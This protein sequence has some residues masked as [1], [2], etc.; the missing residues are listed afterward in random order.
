MSRGVASRDDD[1]AGS[2]MIFRYEIVTTV[3]FVGDT[4]LGS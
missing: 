2:K 4:R 1:C 3:L